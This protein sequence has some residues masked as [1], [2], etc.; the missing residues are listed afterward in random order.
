MIKLSGRTVAR[1]NVGVNLVFK[2]LS[3]YTK[4]L[5]GMRAND[6]VKHWRTHPDEWVRLE[7][8]EE[9]Q[10]MANDGWFVVVGWV[11][12]IPGESGH[13]AVVVPGEME[14]SGT[15]NKK[16]PVCMDTG[17]QMRAKKQSMSLS[18]GSNKIHDVEFYYYK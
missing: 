3:S 11:N 8:G 1:C 15:Y 13:V 7:S 14:W 16:M 12:P 6:M 17:Y 9:A 2:M 4:H 10:R 18:F 5:D